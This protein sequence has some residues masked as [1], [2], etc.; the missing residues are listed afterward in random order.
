MP[1][2]TRGRQVARDLDGSTP[3]D[4]PEPDLAPVRKDGAWAEQTARAEPGRADHAVENDA[5]VRERHQPSRL[6]VD[7]TLDP[8]A[9]PIGA[10]DIADHLGIEAQAPVTVF[11]VDRSEDLLVGLDLDQVAFHQPQ[12]LPRGLVER[13]APERERLAPTATLDDIVQGSEQTIPADLEELPEDPEPE[14]PDDLA[15]P[16]VARPDVAHVLPDV[17]PRQR[18]GGPAHLRH[19]APVPRLGRRPRVD[20]GRGN[21]PSTVAPALGAHRGLHSLRAG[22]RRWVG[23]LRAPGG[24]PLQPRLLPEE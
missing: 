10:A 7:Q 9:H 1:T 20:P 24:Y 4:L 5:V 18:E 15:Y 14:R 23:R 2:V 11:G 13:A 22:R 17:P 19:L 21:E 8:V 16:D 6:L 3:I 12:R